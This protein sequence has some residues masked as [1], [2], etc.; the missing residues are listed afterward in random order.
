MIYLVALFSSV[1]TVFGTSSDVG[2]YLPEPTASRL[3]QLEA[4]GAIDVADLESTAETYNVSEIKDGMLVFIYNIQHRYSKL[5]C[6]EGSLI[7]N[8]D[9]NKG[10]L[11]QLV[12]DETRKGLF[13]LVNWASS[14]GDSTN[15]LAYNG[16]SQS[17]FCYNGPKYD[18]QLW[19]FVKGTDGYWKI[20]N[21]GWYN[22]QC[23]LAVYIDNF[24][25]DSC[26]CPIGRVICP[27]DILVG[28]VPADFDWNF[29]VKPAF[30]S[31][32]I[33][34]IADSW[35]NQTDEDVK[36]TFKYYEGITQSIEQT[37]ALHQS[38]EIS[39]SLGIEGAIEEIGLSESVTE[40]VML[41]FSESYSKAVSKTWSEERKV[42]LPVPA[43]TRICIKQLKVNTNE[44]LQ[45]RA[46]FIFSSRHYRVLK[47]DD[48]N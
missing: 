48:C 11:W 3:A 1:A 29:R 13:F 41:S 34:T 16:P 4:A 6:N 25:R 46:G 17:T 32:A 2:S 14:S 35:D 39:L 45:N 9:V 43:H 37:I 23:G 19:K 30:E 36:Y 12:E 44:N 18:D 26:Q 31:D 8:G 21:E 40:T 22:G 27:N 38:V 5:N 24:F 15:R 20:Q 10:Q 28:P 47:D 7:D 33:W 42:T